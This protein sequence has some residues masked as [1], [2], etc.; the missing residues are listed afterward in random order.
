MTEYQGLRGYMFSAYC[1][2][3]YTGKAPPFDL[4]AVEKMARHTGESRCPGF[5]INGFIDI[6]DSGFRRNDEV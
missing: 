3:T 2:F 6:L 1:V 4:Q 5:K